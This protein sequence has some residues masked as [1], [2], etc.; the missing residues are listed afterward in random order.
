[1][2]RPHLIVLAALVACADPAPAPSETPTP[3]PAPNLC[4]PP[5]PE[6]DVVTIVALHGSRADPRADSSSA[7]GA[8]DPLFTDPA[9]PFDVHFGVTEH[10]LLGTPEL[11]AELA[12]WPATSPMTWSV[13]IPGAD[14]SA[15]VTATHTGLRCIEEVAEQ[16][17]LTDQALSLR[18]RDGVIVHFRRAEEGG[19]YLG[20]WGHPEAWRL[21]DVGFGAVFDRL[22]RILAESPEGEQAWRLV[23]ASCRPPVPGDATLTVAGAESRWAGLGA[24]SAS[25]FTWTLEGDRVAFTAWQR[26]AGR[27][28]AR[29][30]SW[31]GHL[32]ADLLDALGAA[33]LLD[34]HCGPA[35]P[36]RFRTDDYPKRRLEL[37]WSDGTTVEAKSRS[38]GPHGAPWSVST[39]A[40]D[41][42]VGA[43]DTGAVG[44]ARGALVEAAVESAPEWAEAE[45]RPSDRR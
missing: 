23:D 3:P 38:Q 35:E 28:S 15:L 9:R 21:E 31:E 24:T 45:S 2:P 4:D 8:V 30:R 10:R 20:R 43:Q 36:H 12:R 42:P 40:P 34:V 13:V 16:P 7:E 17:A 19:W 26:R 27:T 37:T 44:E 6:G 14:V 29:E 33:A 39:R 25:R 5:R 22:A 18:L 11:Q 1:V 41:A 32:D